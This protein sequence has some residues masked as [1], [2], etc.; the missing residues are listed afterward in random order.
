MCG[1]HV[2]YGL[3]AHSQAGSPPRVREPHLCLKPILQLIRITPA[4]A[5][6]TSDL[7]RVPPVLWDHPRV[8]GN[9]VL[10]FSVRSPGLGSPPRVRE[11]RHKPRPTP[12]TNRITPACA[13][14]TYAGDDNLLPARDHPRV[15]GNHLRPR[16]YGLGTVGSPPR[17]REPLAIYDIIVYGTRITPACAGTTKLDAYILLFVQDHPRVCG[18]HS[19]RECFEDFCG[20]SPPRVREPRVRAVPFDQIS[21][22][23]PACAGTTAPEER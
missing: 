15:C 22:I 18:N 16:Q 21:G 6:T 12:R 7:M 23:T 19:V 1:N 8:C 2:N 4:C 20:G 5:G 10:L 17:V 14:T 3:V 11:P 13:G 9:H